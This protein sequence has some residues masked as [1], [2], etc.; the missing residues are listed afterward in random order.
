MADSGRNGAGRLEQAVARLEQAVVRLESLQTRAPG[1]D[2]EVAALRV[3]CAE[4]ADGARTAN[5]RLDQAIARIRA[6]IAD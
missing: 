6:L 2:G 4:L 3:R 5:Q 1:G